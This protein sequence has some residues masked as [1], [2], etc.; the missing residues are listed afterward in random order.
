METVILVGCLIYAIIFPPHSLL[1][2]FIYSGLIARILYGL[3]IPLIIINA[4]NYIKS[5]GF[6]SMVFGS[7]FMEFVFAIALATTFVFA[8]DVVAKDDPKGKEIL[9]SLFT[10]DDNS[11]DDIRKE[12]NITDEE[13]FLK[14]TFSNSLD[15][16]YEKYDIKKEKD[17]KTLKEMVISETKIV[18]YGYKVTDNEWLDDDNIILYIVDRKTNIYNFYKLNCRTK[19]FVKSS[20]DEWEEAKDKK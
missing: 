17:Y 10:Y 5:E 11:Y 19:D 15:S 9:S 12:K 4:F 6:D 2:N 1:L 14:E 18:K 13:E 7:L 3:F 8:A 16:L 20:M